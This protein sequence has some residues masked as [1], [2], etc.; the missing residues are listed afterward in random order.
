MITILLSLIACG[1]DAT[2]TAMP[3]DAPEVA[4]SC[5]PWRAVETVTCGDD[6]SFPIDLAVGEMSPMVERCAILP[7]GT[8]EC[9]TSDGSGWGQL[10]RV[11]DS[12]GGVDLAAAIITCDPGAYEWSVTRH[13]CS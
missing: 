3:A 2:D 8:Y 6:G 12:P 5:T 11:V 13:G 7:D 9:R 10:I 4:T 1:G